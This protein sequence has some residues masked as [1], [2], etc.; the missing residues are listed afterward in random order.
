MFTGDGDVVGEHGHPDPEDVARERERDSAADALLVP[1]LIHAADPECSFPCN[2]PRDRPAG[3]PD[4]PADH[5]P[6]DA[7]D[8]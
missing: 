1:G 8:L 2:F 4:D 7:A 5:L 6:Q 3:R